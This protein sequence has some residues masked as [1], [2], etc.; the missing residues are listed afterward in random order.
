MEK[1]KILLAVTGF[2]PQRWRELLSAER[3][4]VLEP[5]GASDPSITYAV[6]W[7]QRP[8]LLGSL[9]NLRAIFSIGAGVDHIFSDPSLPDVPIVK[10]VAGNLAQHMTEY[11]VWRVLDHHRQ[12]LLYRSQQPKKI[13][14]E[15]A[16]R[17]AEDISVGIMGL[18]SLG[19]AAASA[20][21]S[22]GFAV[23]GWSRTDRPME[24]VATYWGEAG[25]I[26]F[27][28][29][30]DILVVL[31]PLTADTKG[32]VNYGVLKELRK[33]N[34]LGGSVLINAGRGRLQKDADILR[35]LDDGTLKEASL[36]VFEVEP[37]P[38]TSPLWAHPKVFVTPHAAATSD[39]VH[40]A[41][42]MLRQMDAFERGEKLEN[43]VDRKAGY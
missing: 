16:Q 23:N 30:T 11:V 1:G 17:T 19:R 40:L 18:G 34:G 33:R 36:D 14:R 27:L 8:N 10:V 41:P 7:K 39:P 6:V 12:G 42:I 37:L 20:L 4:V 21:L 26:P 29:A 13:W 31:L 28:N 43:L 9:P 3:E 22:L 38:K 15:P 32:I 25:L 24:G 2:H 5:D 35:A